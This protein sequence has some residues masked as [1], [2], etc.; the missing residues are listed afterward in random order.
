MAESGDESSEFA[1]FRSR[2]CFSIFLPS[3]VLLEV[4][5]DEEKGRTVRMEADRGMNCLHTDGRLFA[6]VFMEKEF[7][8][9]TECRCAGYGGHAS[10]ERR[11]M[12]RTEASHGVAVEDK[13]CK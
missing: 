11:R 6:S 1:G 10:I 8:A 4:W 7:I 12:S 5:G 2:I 9:A 13:E 3:S